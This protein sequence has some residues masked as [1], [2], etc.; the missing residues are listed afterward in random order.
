MP[1]SNIYN[2][3]R[4]FNSVLINF[5]T[6][7]RLLL[8]LYIFVYIQAFLKIVGIVGYF[9]IY[10]IYRENPMNLPGYEYGYYPYYLCDGWQKAGE[11]IY[12]CDGLYFKPKGLYTTL[13][14]LYV[15]DHKCNICKYEWK[16]LMDSPKVCPRCKSYK[17]A[18]PTEGE[19]NEER[20]GNIKN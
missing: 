14:L 20:N 15:M 9:R 6:W 17:W 7:T 8:F 10:G 11:Y 1:R 12:F 5:V 2:S 18:A 13:Y 3:A 19:K 4:V 16:S